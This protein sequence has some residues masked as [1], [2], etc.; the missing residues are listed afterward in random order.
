MSL[1]SLTL[2]QAKLIA[3][4]QGEAKREETSSGWKKEM[5]FCSVAL[6]TPPSFSGLFISYLIHLPFLQLNPS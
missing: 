3:Y 5:S 4:Q 1:P 6:P 2:T